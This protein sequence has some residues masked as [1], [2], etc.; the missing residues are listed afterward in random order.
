MGPTSLFGPAIMKPTILY[1]G[2]GPLFCT[3]YTSATDPVV[4]LAG[5]TPVCNRWIDRIFRVRSAPP[6]AEPIGLEFSIF[7]SLYI[8]N[9]MLI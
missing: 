5:E 7:V 8:E 1:L 4:G 2:F 6:L 3:L 9:Y